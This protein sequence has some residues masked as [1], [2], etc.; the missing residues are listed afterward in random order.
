MVDDDEDDDDNDNDNIERK[1]SP[2]PSI[3]DRH[4]CYRKQRRSLKLSKSTKRDRSSSIRHERRH[5]RCRRHAHRNSANNKQIKKESSKPHRI[6]KPTLSIDRDYSSEDENA[7]LLDREKLRAALRRDIPHSKS[8]TTTSLRKKLKVVK[9]TVAEVIDNDDIDEEEVKSN[10]EIFELLD[11]IVDNSEPQGGTDKETDIEDE[12]ISLE[13]QELR[14]IALKSAIVKK[15]EA[16]KK[17][18]VIEARPYSP[19][20]TDITMEEFNS[21]LSNASYYVQDEPDVCVISPIPSSPP[22]SFDKSLLPVDMDIVCSEASQSPIFF[23][24]MPSQIMNHNPHHHS[25]TN[26]IGPWIPITDIPLPN[27][28]HN[29]VLANDTHHLAAVFKSTLQP[30]MMMVPD[31]VESPKSPEDVEMGDTNYLPDK[32]DSPKSDLLPDNNMPIE[33]N[34]EKNVLPKQEDD[35]HQDDEEEHALRALLIAN[36]GSPKNSKRKLRI[37]DEDQP[38]K[39]DNNQNNSF[40]TLTSS[41]ALTTVHRHKNSVTTN[42]NQHINSAAML[43]HPPTSSSMINNCLS[44]SPLAPTF[45]PII[46]QKE[47]REIIN[48]PNITMNLK[49]AVK[50]IKTKYTTKANQKQTNNV[51]NH[52]HLHQV[53]QLGM[54]HN[55][56]NDGK[57][58]NLIV[59]NLNSKQPPAI[60]E[61]QNLNKN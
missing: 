45:V 52:H 34:T 48:I 22:L 17:R 36:L 25:H 15:H 58:S 26:E 21:K 8:S 49:E 53:K 32:I 19:T 42:E 41:S 28:H 23:N 40:S 9:Q 10:K 55:N 14:L 4:Y 44:L 16:R 50:R 37:I 43:T 61:Q 54:T 39:T 20:D 3:N 29:I 60:A 18:K 33:N 47:N 30:V 7:L 51:G 24:E 11:S 38:P 31:E 46:L 59:V 57:N 12:T 13:E 5:S 2:M 35:S 56:R 6:N 1:I 27:D